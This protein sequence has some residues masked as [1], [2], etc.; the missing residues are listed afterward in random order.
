M[1]NNRNTKRGSKSVLT[2]AI[3]M[4]LALYAL[5]SLGNLAQAASND[6]NVEWAG[7]FHDQGPLSGRQYTVQNGQVTVTVNGHYGVILTQ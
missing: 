2:I 6:N 4:A 1:S 3:S 7:L 5:P